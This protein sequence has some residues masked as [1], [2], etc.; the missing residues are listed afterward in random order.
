MKKVSSIFIFTILLILSSCND[1]F[2][3]G[4]DFLYAEASS[5]SDGG[6]SPNGG[7]QGNN[8]G[9]ITAGEWNDLNN[10]NFWNDL[11]NNETY[12]NKS[13]YWRFYTNNRISVNVK[14]N[15]SPVINETVILKKNNITIWETK[16]DNFGNAEL[17]IGLFQ[18]ESIIDLTDYK[19]LVNGQEVSSTLKLFEDGVVSLNL[20]ISQNNVL[21]KVE[22]AFIVDATGSMSDELHFL[23]DDLNDVIQRVK[24]A[25]TSLDILTSTVFYRDIGDAYVVKQSSFTNNISETIN[26]ISQQSASGGGDFPEAVHTALNE[27][28]NNLQWSTNSKT[29]IAFL[30]LDAPPHYDTQIIDNLHVIIKT[31]SQKGIKLIPVTASGI[32]KDTEFLMRFFSIATN[33]TYVFITNDS[34]IGN[35]HLI[36]SVGEYQV[37]NLNDLMVRIITKYSN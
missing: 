30:I 16:T 34:G 13:D 24:S 1:G 6:G 21:N 4:D 2:T 9:L 26:F 10:W 14:Q 19:L 35:D 27:G 28:I 33:G 23:K 12:S 31:A 15:N 5:S 29:R 7:G 32:D 25:N 11:L 18:K 8:S 20:N 3:S 37:E 36:A 22:L 17:W